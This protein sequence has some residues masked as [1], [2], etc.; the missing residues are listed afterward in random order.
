MKEEPDEGSPDDPAAPE[1]E[2]RT[3]VEQQ[4]GDDWIE[5][6]PGVYRFTG[7]DST[8]SRSSDGLET[9]RWN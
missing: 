2:R 9:P 6:E 3:W 8:A 1:E 5:V 7:A 4:L